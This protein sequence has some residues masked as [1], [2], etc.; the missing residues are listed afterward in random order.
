MN[1]DKEMRVRLWDHLAKNFSGWDS[2][3]EIERMDL[4]RAAVIG[5]Y[6]S[7]EEMCAELDQV[8]TMY[9]AR[10]DDEVNQHESS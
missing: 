5:Y 7:E 1:H 9:S 10:D 4:H 3:R 6:L 8:L 2:M